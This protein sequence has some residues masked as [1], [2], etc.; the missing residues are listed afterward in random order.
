M[1]MGYFGTSGPRQDASVYTLGAGMKRAA[2][3]KAMRARAQS[4]HYHP[5]SDPVRA[6]WGK[7]PGGETQGSHGYTHTHLG[8]PGSGL[9]KKLDGSDIVVGL[10]I[11]L[12]VYL[13]MRRGRKPREVRGTQGA[14]YAV[15]G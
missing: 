15:F 10:A 13:Y 7:Y 4:T 1:I 8:Y 11:G 2:N 5:F 14:E 3:A 6:H 12:A 9:V